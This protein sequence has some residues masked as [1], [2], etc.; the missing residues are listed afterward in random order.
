VFLDVSLILP[1]TCTCSSRHSL[2]PSNCRAN[3]RLQAANVDGI[4]GCSEFNFVNIIMQQYLSTKILQLPSCA[5]SA[6]LCRKQARHRGPWK[7]V[8]SKEGCILLHIMT[9]RAEDAHA[10]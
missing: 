9:I 10:V 4:H 2:V 5:A 1:S 6:R 3:K 8:Y 7:V